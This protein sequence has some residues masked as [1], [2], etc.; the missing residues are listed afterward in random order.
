M[1]SNLLLV[2]Q[3]QFLIHST[4][5]QAPNSFTK[6]II[7]IILYELTFTADGEYCLVV[8]NTL[9]PIYCHEMNT[10]NPKEYITFR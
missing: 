10:A 3:V 2:Q 7:I 8:Q 1:N 5:L 6:L 9:V 4:I